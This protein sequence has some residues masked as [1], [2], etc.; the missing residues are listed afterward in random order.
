MQ[1]SR[2]LQGGVSAAGGVLCVH[3][4]GRGHHLRILPQHV[5]LLPSAASHSPEPVPHRAADLPLP[6]LPLHVRLLRNLQAG[7]LQL[8]PTC[9]QVHFIHS[10]SL[11]ALSVFA[12]NAQW[13]VA[14]H[15]HTAC[16]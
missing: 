4:A 5:S 9:P 8:L 13:C 12:G 1:Q 6:L 3:C 2:G 15:V 11:V 10:E 14:C 16:V 7:P